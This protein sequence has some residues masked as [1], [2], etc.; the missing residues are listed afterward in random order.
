MTKENTEMEKLAPALLADWT[1]KYMLEN[2]QCDL[3]QFRKDSKE[4]LDSL[5]TEENL[6]NDQERRIYQ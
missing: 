4:F 1:V 6:K 3:D 5:L 2:P